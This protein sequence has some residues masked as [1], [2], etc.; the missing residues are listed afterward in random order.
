M[1]NF[2]K[3]SA[4]KVTDAIEKGTSI[5]FKHIIIRIQRVIESGSEFKFLGK[6]K[7]DVVPP[8]FL[9][10]GEINNT[11]RSLAEAVNN[12]LS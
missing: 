11:P 5:V 6:L 12:S 8:R 7:T 10:S 4:I 9:L 2:R 1:F 3:R